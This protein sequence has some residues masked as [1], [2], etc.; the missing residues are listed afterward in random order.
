MRRHYNLLATLLLITTMGCTLIQES[1]QTMLEASDYDSIV[2]VRP[3]DSSTMVQE[4]AEIFQNYWAQ[5]TGHMAALQELPAEDQFNVWIGF[6]TVPAKWLESAK[7]DTLG[8]DGI[9]I[10]TLDER[11]L[12]IGGE[13]DR[14]VQYAVYEFFDRYMG[15]RWLDP[16]VVH[17][18]EAPPAA[19]ATMNHVYTPPFSWREAYYRH[20][21]SPEQVEYR[22]AHKLSNDRMTTAFGGHSFYRWMPPEVYFDEHPEYFSLVDGERRALKGPIPEFVDWTDY[23]RDNAGQLCMTNEEMLGVMADR[24]IEHFRAHPGQ[25]FVSVSQMDWSRYC[26]CDECTAVNEREG[27]PI[28]HILYGVNRVAELVEAEVPGKKIHTFSYDWSTRPPDTMKPRENVIIQYCTIRADTSRSIGDPDSKLNRAFAEELRGWGQLTDNVHVWDYTPNFRTWIAPHP[29]FHTLIP[30]LRFFAECNVNSVFEQGCPWPQGEMVPLRTYLLGK[31]LWD[32]SI[33]W[34][35]TMNEF[36]ELYYGPAA[37]QIKE[38]VAL[39]TETQRASGQEMTCYDECYWVTAEM[40]AA[41]RKLFDE[42]AA[43]TR[44]TPYADRVKLARLP[45]EYAAIICA[46]R[47]KA[48]GGMI[49]LKRP[50]SLSAE[51]YVEMMRAEGLGQ[52]GEQNSIDTFPGR[53]ENGTVPPREAVSPLVTLEDSEQLLW[54]A[55]HFEGSVLRWHL[56]DRGI[57]LLRGYQTYNGRRPGTWQDWLNTPRQEEGPA[58][59]F[60]DVIEDSG[61]NLTI[62]AET[63]EG[64]VIERRMTLLPEGVLEVSLSLTNTTDE[65]VDANVKT[66]P[67]FYTQGPAVPEIWALDGQGWQHLNE[68]WVSTELAHGEYLEVGDYTAWAIRMPPEELVLVNRFNPEQLGG[69]LWFINVKNGIEQANLELLPVDQPLGAGESRTVVSQYEV[70]SELP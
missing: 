32:P 68:D 50:E 37:P 34:E 21:I 9:A 44:G 56:K 7:V 24:I 38:Y 64:L 25:E 51:A 15:V 43:A 46:P 27:G 36:I 58:S 70:T 31:G 16:G 63:D 26:E 18:P 54:I 23:H 52:I 10:V 67:E 11:N 45:V 47:I 33:D 28:G 8:P 62:R 57:E 4:A 60:Y 13:N 39:M 17:V 14:A 61:K 1:P 12:L 49:S 40:V 2:I 29:N 41:A 20:G 65:E 6:G 35:A 66:H 42:A 5:T 48:S 3:V 19:L 69:L 55:P 30:T 22:R 59:F 53:F